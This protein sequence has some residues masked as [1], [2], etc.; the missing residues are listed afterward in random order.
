[1]GLSDKQIEH[2]KE[3]K[4]FELLTHIEHRI[5]K[6]GEVANIPEDKV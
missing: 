2:L 1:M 5:S 6:A 3:I 4:E